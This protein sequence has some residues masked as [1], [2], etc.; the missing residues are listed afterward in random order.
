MADVIKARRR[1]EFRKKSANL[2]R[3]LPTT[4]TPDD[5]LEIPQKSA[6]DNSL[7]WPLIPFPDG[8]LTG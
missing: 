7:D 1:A 8:W 5:R 6:N 4:A 2:E 3:Q